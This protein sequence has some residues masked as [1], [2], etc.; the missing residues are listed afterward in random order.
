MR[1]ALDAH[2]ST[3][4]GILPRGEPLPFPAPAARAGRRRKRAV[5]PDIPTSGEDERGDAVRGSPTALSRPQVAAF[6]ARLAGLP[7]LVAL[8]QYGCGL[9]LIEAVRLRVADLDL[10]R[11][12]VMVRAAAGMDRVVPLPAAVVTPLRGLL[13][14]R[15]RQHLMERRGDGRGAVAPAQAA[16]KPPAAAGHWLRQYVFAGAEGCADPGQERAGRLHLDPHLVEGIHRLAFRAAGIRAPVCSHTLRECF[17]HH[18]LARG[19]D[20]GVLRDLLGHGAIA[21]T[22]SGNGD[23]AHPVGVALPVDELMRA[24]G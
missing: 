18:L 9:H 10:E 23:P 3:Q 21:A 20:P 12:V 1:A 6:F 13:A 14:E 22:R 5:D 24:M 19:F 16:R 2:S 17:A 4:P 7:R 15:L 11:R 8:L